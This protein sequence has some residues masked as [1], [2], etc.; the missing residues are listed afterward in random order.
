MNT[1]RVHILSYCCKKVSDS[2]MLSVNA[3][4]LLYSAYRSCTT[5]RFIISFYAISFTLADMR[6]AY[7]NVKIYQTLK[8][9][10]NEFYLK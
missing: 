3:S 9:L 8:N 2:A 1:A 7:N 4:V 5:K 6:E 10:M